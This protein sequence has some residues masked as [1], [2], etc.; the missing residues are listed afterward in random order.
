M[1]KQLA[2]FNKHQ[3]FKISAYLKGKN[4]KTYAEKQMYASEFIRENSQK[5]RKEF[6]GSLCP[7]RN[8]CIK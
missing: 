1:C 5:M 7:E 6:C 2:L 8:I 4:P 3:I